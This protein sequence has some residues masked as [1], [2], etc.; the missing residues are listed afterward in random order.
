MIRDDLSAIYSHPPSPAQCFPPFNDVE[1]DLSRFRLVRGSDVRGRLFSRARTADDLEH[2]R[3]RRERHSEAQAILASTQMPCYWSCPVEDCQQDR[4]P[5]P[6]PLTRISPPNSS[7][8][9]NDQA[10]PEPAPSHPCPLSHH[11]LS[12]FPAYSP[13][14]EPPNHPRP[15]FLPPAHSRSR[16]YNPS[17]GSQNLLLTSIFT[18][19]IPSASARSQILATGQNPAASLAPLTPLPRKLPPADPNSEATRRVALP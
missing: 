19:S 8:R 17:F 9:E 3:K 16:L 5:L 12:P 11:S 1:L 18:S 6:P 13:T 2:P 15:S 7:P 10:D 4:L 14:S